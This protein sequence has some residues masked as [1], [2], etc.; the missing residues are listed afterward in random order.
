MSSIQSNNPPI[1]TYLQNAKGLAEDIV[2]PEKR[3]I[4][5]N[6]YIPYYRTPHTYYYYD[7]GPYFGRSIHHY[8]HSSSSGVIITILH[9]YVQL[10]LLLI[11]YFIHYLL[12]KQITLEI[13]QG[14]VM[15]QIMLS[16]R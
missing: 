5:G 2:I 14:G 16:I 12:I 3:F 10:S 13:R 11:H 1:Y 9:L 7:H 8:H 4:D 15:K 6:N